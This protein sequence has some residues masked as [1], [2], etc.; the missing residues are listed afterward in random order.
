MQQID[1]I[2]WI[3]RLILR[4]F[5][6]AELKPEER[7]FIE[8]NVRK[9]RIALWVNV[10]A[11]PFVLLGLRQTAPGDIGTVIMALIAPVMMLGGAW[12]G[13]SFGGV[14]QKLID[15][16][17]LTTLFMFTAFIVSLSTMFVAVAFISSPYLW[18]VL[19]VI[20][21]GAL[22]A[23]IQYD[24]ADGLKAGLDDAL[25]RHSRAA[26]RYYREKQGIDV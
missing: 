20:Y 26:L 23:F 24:T 15:I 1:P 18:P 11:I 4:G 12:F 5:F 8:D 6:K 16:A 7:A 22:A 13:I 10:V 21:L 25:L 3:L 9:H 19:L 14:P 2:Y 17:M